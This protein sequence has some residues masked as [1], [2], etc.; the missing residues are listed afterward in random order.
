MRTV[1]DFDTISEKFNVKS[2][3]KTYKNNVKYDKLYQ[4]RKTGWK[5]GRAMLAIE[6]KNEILAIL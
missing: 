4:R 3:K 2:Q 6:R 1:V 5:R